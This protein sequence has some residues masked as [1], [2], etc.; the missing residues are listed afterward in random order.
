MIATIQEA[1]LVAALAVSGRMF[2]GA[3]GF[4][5]VWA[6]AAMSLPTGVC[7][8]TLVGAVLLL[9]PIPAYPLAAL[10]VALLAA[11]AAG[12]LTANGRVSWRRREALVT[13][14]IGTAVF[15]GAAVI[16]EATFVSVSPDSYRYL[17]TAGIVGLT[18]GL[19]H[20]NAFLLE[21]RGWTFPYVHALA[22]PIGTRF[23]VS[24]G[25]LLA[26]SGLA[27]VVWF[28]RQLGR[29][30][31]RFWFALAAPVAFVATTE[32]FVYHAVYLN[33]HMLFAVLAAV[34]AGLLALT[35]HGRLPEETRPVPVALLGLAALS[36]VRPEAPLVAALLI[37][38]ALVAP[39]Q[40][41][42][43]A[44]LAGAI[45]IPTA[46][47]F[48][49][50]MWMYTAEG[51]DVSMTA[52]GMLVFALGTLAVAFAVSHVGDWVPSRA[53]DAI[54][55]L[56]LVGLLGLG[57]TQPRLLID[58]LTATARNVV[59]DGLWGL[60]LI[61]LVSLLAIAYYQVDS[62]VGR[63]SFGLPLVAFIPFAFVLA[64]LRGGAY[65]VGPGDSLNRMMVHLILVA[66][67]ALVAAVVS[68]SQD[69]PR[70]SR[71]S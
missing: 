29:W 36:L 52:S 5:E 33:A 15:L 59:L 11:I 64:H 23:L 54:P 62:F 19:E 26:A 31:R 18:G 12:M 56:L 27:M 37:G 51:R 17:T 6:A 69:A 60:S 57:A 65:R 13:A 61:L 34:V 43:K 25:P 20:A 50:V 39:L 21:S 35:L 67:M 9:L 71:R 55:V 32:R 53:A 16:R 1:L 30:D 45:A 14:A 38:P 8:Y 49:G 58:S 28:A 7:V 24:V 2:L 40:R 63:H 4:L 3:L 10:A 66:A 44:A 22:A 47:W 68:T 46:T 70:S 41:R 42:H 48:G